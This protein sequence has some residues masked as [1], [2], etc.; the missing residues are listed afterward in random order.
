MIT[1][2]EKQH[3][4]WSQFF[5]SA[6][7]TSSIGRT[8]LKSDS[9]P[10]SQWLKWTIVPKTPSIAKIARRA[11]LEGTLAYTSHVYNSFLRIP[12]IPESHASAVAY[13]ALSAV[14]LEASSM[15]HESRESK[16]TF[17]QFGTSKKTGWEGRGLGPV[18]LTDINTQGN[19]RGT[20]V[21]IADTAK[22][23]FGRDG[24]PVYVG[25]TPL[26]EKERKRIAMAKWLAPDMPTYAQSAAS[27]FFWAVAFNKGPLP[28][29]IT[30]EK[31]V[32]KWNAGVVEASSQG[33][34]FTSA[35]IQ[36]INSWYKFGTTKHK[37]L[38]AGA[39][40]FLFACS[41]MA[42]VDSDPIWNW[43]RRP[44]GSVTQPIPTPKSN[45]LMGKELLKAIDAWIPGDQSTEKPAFKAP[46]LRGENQD[47]VI[48]ET[49]NSQTNNGS[50]RNRH[51][52]SDQR[53]SVQSE[54]SDITKL[55]NSTNIYD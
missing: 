13:T 2:T 43:F 39:D 25:N 11:F 15:S 17:Y 46:L 33:I 36:L 12:G 53:T 42:S 20:F 34:P 51:A 27:Y 1:M 47:I 40:A 37:V 18:Q 8:M 41:Q 9:G 48:L 4:Q 55:K 10:S 6:L 38:V 54:E 22:L 52:Y 49:K 3:L 35:M 14:A 50:T 31:A 32:S 5:T 21:Q 7:Q 23:L 16:Q 44:A 45:S 28:S 30:K 19:E 29:T 26:E 24:Y